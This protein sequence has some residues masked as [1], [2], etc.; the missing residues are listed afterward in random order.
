MRG[1]G[2]TAAIGLQ[3]V[4]DSLRKSLILLKFFLFTFAPSLAIMILWLS[5][6]TLSKPET[7]GSA[8]V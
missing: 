6:I 5:N 2:R 3:E 4:Q 8:I 1:Q 7:I